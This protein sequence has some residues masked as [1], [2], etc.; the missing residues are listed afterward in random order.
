MT[1]FI[2]LKQ[3]LRKNI[4]FFIC[5]IIQLIICLIMFN[6][7]INYYSNI[8][9]KK[10][11]IN[12]YINDN[13]ILIQDMSYLNAQ[14]DF[15][16]RK[17]K[18][19]NFLHQIDNIKCIQNFSYYTLS[20]NYIKYRAYGLEK[21]F[22]SNITPKLIAGNWLNEEINDNYMPIVVI[23]GYFDLN[24]VINFKNEDKNIQCKVIG[25]IS[26]ND[27]TIF[28]NDGNNYPS[29]SNTLFY[30]N[31]LN[32]PIIYFINDDIQKYEFI[33]N[34]DYNLKKIIIFNKNI[35]E[36]EF[37]NNLDL[38]NSYYQGY[39]LATIQ[40]NSK[41]EMKIINNILLPI[42]I[43]VIIAFI[44]SLN[45]FIIITLL[46]NNYDNYIYIL[47]GLKSKQLF[48][49]YFWL[50]VILFFISTI[51]FLPI[52]FSLNFNYFINLSN[53]INLIN[54][55][56]ILLYFIVI[57]SIMALYNNH[58]YKINIKKTW[59]TKKS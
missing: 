56:C 31:E 25:I 59:R 7:L 40:K 4:N 23:E 42:V 45:A 9:Y 55:I 52:Y 29:Y 10:N 50:I 32:F 38:I 13:S 14:L 34:E 20:K 41:E 24:S 43:A 27:V 28:S 16:E 49:I 58:Y 57:V 35:T 15:D 44:I 2:I 48:Y 19:S 37:K 11:N 36:I 17:E 39:D 12:E 3:I 5:I 21:E 8:Y 33:P 54:I 30:Y 26:E 22:L 47:C 53:N 46:R 51:I 6:F 1:K 18:F